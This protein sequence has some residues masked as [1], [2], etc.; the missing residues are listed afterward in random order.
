VENFRPESSLHRPETLVQL[1]YS[2]Q[3]I[4]GRFRV[5]DRY[6]LCR[7]MGYFTDVW[8]D[9]CVEFFVQP[10][11]ANGY[12]NFE[13]NCGGSFLCSY[14]VDPRRVEGGFKQFTRIPWSQAQ[15]VR[16]KSSLPARIEPEI[17]S[18]LDWELEFFIPFSLLTA[19]APSAGHP[20]GETWRG[21]FHKCAEDNSHPHWATWAPVD[22]LNFHLPR[23]FGQLE[24]AP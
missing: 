1:L 2:Q 22:E 10:G 24:F 15:V 3:G 17:Q 21:N 11:G 18:P 4:H 16:V 23:C 12:F 20:A 14:I 6:V 13:F 19:Y 8:K 9:S 5:R 7:R